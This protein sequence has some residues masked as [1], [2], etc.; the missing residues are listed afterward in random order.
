MFGQCFKGFSVD[1]MKKDWTIRSIDFDDIL[2]IHKYS[3]KK[4]NMNVLIYLMFIGVIN[5]CTT[6]SFG[7]SLT[8]SSDGCVK[9]VSLNNRPCQ[10]RP[11]LFNIN[12]NEPF[13]YPFTVNV[14]R[15]G[16]NCKTILLMIQRVMYVFQIN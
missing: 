7:V 2:D 8:S 10:V 5:A 3:M 14:N 16:G 4:H 9:C 12:S 1:N 6:G 11:G 13:Y 15:C